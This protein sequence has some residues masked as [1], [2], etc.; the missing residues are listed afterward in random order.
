MDSAM[1]LSDGEFKATFGSPMRRLSLDQ[2]PSFD[3]W[4]YFERIPVQDFEG[5]DRSAGSITHVW[6]SPDRRFQHVLVNSE[7]K[8]V[9]MVIVLDV[10]ASNVAGHHLL[11]VNREYGLNCADQLAQGD[12]CRSS[13]PAA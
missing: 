10:L 13:E 5:N 1:R 9:F 7:D 2:S 6:E 8:N 4:R 3:L 12:G 11:N